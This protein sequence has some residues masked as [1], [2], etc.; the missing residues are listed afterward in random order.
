DSGDS[1]ER[2]ICEYVSGMTDRYAISEYKKLFTP[3]E[4][5]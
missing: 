3:D 2:K 1:L 5:D 4:R